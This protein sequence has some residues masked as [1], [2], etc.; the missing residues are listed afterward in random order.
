MMSPPALFRVK[1]MPYWVLTALFALAFDLT[2]AIPATSGDLESKSGP[3]AALERSRVILRQAGA[4]SAQLSEFDSQMS[5]VWPEELPQVEDYLRQQSPRDL[6]RYIESLRQNSPDDKYT[7]GPDYAIRSDVP[8]GK[9][10]EF[11]LDRSNIF[12][13]TIRRIRVYVP[14]EY[15]AATPACVYVSLDDLPFPLPRA[16]DNL[17]HDHQ[18]PTLIAVGVG[19]GT[20]KSGNP[21]DPRYDRSLEFDGLND[22]LAQFLLEEV[23][24]EVA[25]HKTPKGLP[26][27]LSN[28]PNDRAVGGFSTGGIGAFTIAW[29]RPDAFRRVFT[30][31]GTFVGMRGGDRYPVLVRKTEPKPIRIF[32]QDGSND[33]LTEWLGEVGDW[34]MG[35]QTMER[36]LEF[37]GYQVDH[38]WGEGTHNTRHPTAVLPQALRWL[39]KDWPEPVTARPSQ[40]TFLKRILRPEEQW[41]LVPGDYR[42]AGLLA[43]GPDGT[44][45]F[46]D[47]DSQKAWKLLAGGTATNSSDPPSAY[48]AMAYGPDGK[49]YATD[50]TG[51]R[52]LSYGPNGKSAVIVEN[53]SASNLIVTHNNFIYLTTHS[54]VHSQGGLWLIRPSGEKRLLDDG[55]HDPSG[56]AVSPDGDWLA[57]AESASH[58]GYSY[59]IER[60]GS[61][62]SR[63]QFYWFHT[64][65]EDSGSGVESWTMDRDGHLYAATR[66]GIQVFDRNGRV[67]AI[68]PTPGGPVL[69]LAFGGPKFDILFVSCADHKL[70]RRVVQTV[71]AQTWAPPLKEPPESAG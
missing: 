1:S 58:W 51:Q 9:T 53:V 45:R 65:D 55:L 36:A 48:T 44:V 42:S 50:Q 6:A 56:V 4:S 54:T 69:G 68:L 16:L 63:Q 31:I 14:A 49:I 57:V 3:S 59:R 23:L 70:Y 24:P 15:T 67:R 34:W 7:L 2:V 38:V 18:I 66:L 71:G 27:V 25:R 11:T 40:N 22:H 64:A 43:A 61:V 17:I 5:L 52:V 13:G 26:I 32:M 30:G 41:Q 47:A 28:N 29:E 37:A 20:V 10:F 8:Q 33:E 21:D 19:S 62:D 12:P 39:W 60:D 35:N 46:W